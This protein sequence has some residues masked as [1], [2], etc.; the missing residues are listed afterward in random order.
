MAPKDVRPDCPRVVRRPNDLVA[1]CCGQCNYPCAHRCATDLKMRFSFILKEHEHLFKSSEID[2]VR[3]YKFWRYYA[4]EYLKCMHNSPYLAYGRKIE[5][6]YY[7]PQ[8][9]P[10]E[11]PSPV[12]GKIPYLPD[13]E[14]CQYCKPAR[15]HDRRFI[16][17]CR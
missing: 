9:H 12:D 10:T 17:R 13:T 2:S 3:Y 11:R 6:M 4:S 15:T 14:I 8:P 1:T 7:G 5:H 16:K